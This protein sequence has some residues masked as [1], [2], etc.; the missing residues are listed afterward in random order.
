MGNYAEVITRALTEF[1]SSVPKSALSKSDNPK[2]DCEKIIS[3]ASWRAAGVAGTLAL[4]PGPL[5]MLTIIPDLVAIWKIQ[6]QMVSDIG[7]LYGKTAELQKES[8]MYCLFKHGGSYLFQDIIVRV[9]GRIL[10][11]RA[12]LKII[13]SIISKVGLRISQKI[14][15][16][17]IARWIPLAGAAAVAAYAKYDTAEIG[18]TSMDFFS[19]E[20]DNPVIH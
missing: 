1:I 18:R 9:G 4:P 14:I 13:Q 8:M 7:A 15:V 10:V 19:L 16:R 2:E 3:S 20:I 12:S 5:G 11:K 17:G 6:A